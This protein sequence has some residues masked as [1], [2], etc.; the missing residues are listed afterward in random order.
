MQELAQHHIDGMRAF[1]EFTTL[2]NLRYENQR[3]Y[4][5]NAQTKLNYTL[6]H[7]P[8]LNS[9]FSS[10]DEYFKERGYLEVERTLRHD[11]AVKKKMKK[12]GFWKKLKGKQKGKGE[13]SNQE[14]ERKKKGKQAKK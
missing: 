3:D 14:E 11:E 8:G 9:A 5:M 10:Y 2:H 12:V 6:E 7:M 4:D 1:K 13:T